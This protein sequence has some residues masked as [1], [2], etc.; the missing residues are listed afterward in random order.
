MNTTTDVKYKLTTKGKEAVQNYINYVNE[1]R[2][3]LIQPDEKNIDIM[4]L[5]EDS[6][7]DDVNFTGVDENNIYW[8]NWPLT[9]DLD[10][11]TP[12]VLRVGIEIVPA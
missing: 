7:I 1:E 6:I 10:T 12:I 4:P 8:N 9:E 3:R 2:Q 11:N 5:T